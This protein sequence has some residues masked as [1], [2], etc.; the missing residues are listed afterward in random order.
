[1]GGTGPGVFSAGVG[2]EGRN[3]SIWIKRPGSRRAGSGVPL[4]QDPFLSELGWGH[5][6]QRKPLGSLLG[7]RF[8]FGGRERVD[9]RAFVLDRGREER[10]PAES[11]ARAQMPADGAGAGGGM[12]LER[13]S[14]PRSEMAGGGRAPERGAELTPEPPLASPREHFNE[15][16]SCN[17]TERALTMLIT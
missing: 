15:A 7:A 16:H 11:G 14:E 3:S 4:P 5:E 9:G 8:S 12:G 13:A 1:M 10:V 2:R 17:S 6:D